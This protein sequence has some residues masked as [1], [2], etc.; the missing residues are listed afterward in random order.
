[1][2]RTIAIPRDV[3]GV[4]ELVR[5]FSNWGRW[6]SE[7][8]RGTLNHI[9]PVEVAAAAALVRSGQVFSL[10]IPLDEN[11]PQ[12]GTLGRTNPVHL[13][14]QDGGDVANG[15]QE[16]LRMQYTDDAV[17]MVLQCGTQ[18]DAIAHYFF[19]N[20]MYNGHGTEQV[21]SRGALRNGIDK[22]AD[23]LLGRGVLLDLP[24]HQGI[25]WLA[26]TQPIHG[27]DLLGCAAA[28]GVEIGKGDILLIRT[29]QLARTI[30]QGSWGDYCGG[31]AP[32]LST[33]CVPVLAEREIAAVATDTWTVEVWPSEVPGVSG[34][35][36]DI[37]IVGMGMTLGEIFDLEALAADCAADGRYEFLLAAPP[38]TVT[39]GV[40]SP[41]NPLAVK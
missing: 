32:G 36:H 7:D 5:R 37:L 23:K 40:G 6:G 11:G 41:I 17:Y 33:T 39:G 9:G 19:E 1:M 38:L 15:S 3:D 34:V 2:S 16:H 25:P 28:Q 22:V 14:L 12:A 18:W 10:A 4:R 26:P 27:S 20:Q 24:R 31:P 29:G 8:E 13:M 30:G 21:T 35:M